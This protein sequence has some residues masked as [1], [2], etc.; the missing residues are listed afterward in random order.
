[1]HLL[2]RSLQQASGP[3]PGGTRPG[4]TDPASPA[5]TR[6]ALARHAPA[7]A[8]L[9]GPAAS[10]AARPPRAPH[11]PR[12]QG[13]SPR[14]PGRT[15]APPPAGTACHASTSPHRARRSAATGPAP[16]ALVQTAGG[17]SAAAMLA[18]PTPRRSGTRRGDAHGQPG[19]G[20]RHAWPTPAPAPR[21][22]PRN[23]RPGGN[24]GRRPRRPAS[25]TV[26]RR[27]FGRCR[28]VPQRPRRP[29]RRGRQ[30][31]SGQV[32][33]PRQRPRAT[34]FGAWPLRPQRFY[35]QRVARG[36]SQRCRAFLPQRPQRLPTPRRLLRR[37]HATRHTS[38]AVKRLRTP[39]AWVV[40]AHRAPYAPAYNPRARCGQWRT[41][42]GSGAT[43]LATI[44][45]VSTRGRQLVWHDQAGGLTSTIPF[46]CTDDQCI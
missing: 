33:P 2:E 43:A 5:T 38:R 7:C 22:G 24:K 21:P 31:P 17:S 19:P 32:P 37:E 36:T 3:V 18:P 11:A 9:E 25:A 34:L 46:H 23:K 10:P 14:G 4:S 42:Q 40:R 29:P 27:R 6:R 45:D 8:G 41:A 16:A 26:G 20:A 28:A 30:G 44:A 35:G 13:V 12:A 39:H 1:M 15:P